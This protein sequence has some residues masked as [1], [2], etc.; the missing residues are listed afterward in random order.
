[1]SFNFI[2]SASITLEIDKIKYKY[3]ITLKS[4]IPSIKK[5]LP[6]DQHTVHHQ[7]DVYSLKSSCAVYFRIYC[8]FIYSVEQGVW[9]HYDIIPDAT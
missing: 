6:E 8:T 5:C 1:M 2:Y 4:S 7:F 3:K 9:H